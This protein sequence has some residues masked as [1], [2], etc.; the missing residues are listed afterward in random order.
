MPS[1]LI[2]DDEKSLREILEIIFTNEGF[3]V[4]LARN[5]A[6]AKKIIDNYK[7]DIILS[8]LVVGKENGLDFIRYTY[9]NYPGI[10]SLL[11]TA[12]AS[13]DTAMESIKLGVVDYISKPFDNDELVKM[14]KSIICK[15]CDKKYPDE[16]NKIIGKSRFVDELKDRIIDIAAG[17]SS[18]LIT[19]ESGTGKELVARAIHELSGR[20][21]KPFIPINCGAIPSE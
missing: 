4:F 20:K 3:S 13:P 9:E 14:V 6:E 1:I 5:I 10:P 21:N 12:Y 19:G 17:D 7:I 16:L 11:I 8:D 18:V 2:L 15:E